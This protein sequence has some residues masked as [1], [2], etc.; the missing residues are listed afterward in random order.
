MK[1]LYLMKPKGIITRFNQTSPDGTAYPQNEDDM[2]V[3]KEQ[4]ARYKDF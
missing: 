4:R 1:T 2:G 3:P